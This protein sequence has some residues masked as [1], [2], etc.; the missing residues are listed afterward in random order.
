MRKS[1]RSFSGSYNGADSVLNTR[2]V[3]K[4][5][6]VKPARLKVNTEQLIPLL[7]FPINSEFRHG[8]YLH[9]SDLTKNVCLRMLSLSDHYNMQVPSEQLWPNSR[10]TFSQGHAIA[11]VVL[12]D[13]KQSSP[14][15]VYGRW[16]C[17][18]SVSTF[19]GTYQ[20]SLDRGNC[21]HCKKPM[22]SYVE[23]FYVDD[24]YKISGSVDL[25]LQ[26]AGGLYI[27]EIKSKKGELWKA[28]SAPDPDHLIQAV[29]YYWLMV[30]NN[31]PVHDKLSILY[32][33]KAHSWKSPYKEFTI[34]PSD[35]LRRLDDY[36][37][38]AKEYA[39]YRKTGEIPTKVHCATNS[40]AKAKSC[41]VVTPCFDYY[42][43]EKADA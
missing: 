31:L 29:F 5:K 26:I 14:K 35:H 3:A 16:T 15:E 9:V 38:E 7:N 43:L 10:V 20:Q 22:T 42:E 12:S 1:I 2:R 13:V 6:V 33:S 39:N 32:V 30:R 25:L 28:L 19:E 4:V 17:P 24:E 23:C 41:H 40:C 8:E 37:D 27:T 11:D 36:L 18:C 21:N 34:K